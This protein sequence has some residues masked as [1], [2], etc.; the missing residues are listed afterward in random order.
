MQAV[1]PVDIHVENDWHNRLESKANRKTL[2]RQD[3]QAP[4]M[5]TRVSN[6]TKPKKTVLLSTRI[7]K[8]VVTPKVVPQTRS[9]TP[10]PNRGPWYE[11]ETLKSS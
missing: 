3:R 11:G 10:S 9:R 5:R 4:R 2:P 1:T 7:P 8:Q 6:K